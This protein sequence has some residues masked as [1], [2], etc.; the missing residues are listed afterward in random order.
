MLL[1]HLHV[2]VC[3]PAFSNLYNIGDM[4][5]A[6]V[7]VMSKSNINT[8]NM[9]PWLSGAAT[10]QL[11]PTTG[12]DDGVGGHGGEAHTGHPLGVA[13]GLTDGVLALAQ[14]VPQ[15]DGLVTG[16]GDNLPNKQNPGS[17]TYWLGQGMMF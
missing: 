14:G 13:L 17:I 3:K 10:H 5:I 12:H 6:H 11:V 1:E 2:H 4:G 16:T 15:L 8:N 9:I 7:R